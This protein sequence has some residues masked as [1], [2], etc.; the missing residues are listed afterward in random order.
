MAS[1]SG[2]PENLKEM[3]AAPRALGRSWSAEQCGFAHSPLAR[4]RR[5]K[6]HHTAL[7]RSSLDLFDFLTI[8]LTK[9]A[10]CPFPNAF[11]SHE[12]AAVLCT[13]PWLRRWLGPRLHAAHLH[14]ALVSFGRGALAVRA[15]RK[16]HR[17]LTLGSLFEGIDWKEWRASISKWYHTVILFFWAGKGT[18]STELSALGL[19]RAQPDP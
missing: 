9:Q 2:H 8:D 10:F 18:P 13:W 17:L 6:R 15:G 16:V 12:L 1:R 7:G 5:G 4:E 3:R 14:N 11:P 19:G